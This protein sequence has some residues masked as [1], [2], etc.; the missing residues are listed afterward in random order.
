M[1][2]CYIFLCNFNENAYLC[3]KKCDMEQFNI[4]KFARKVGGGQRARNYLTDSMALILDSDQMGREMFLNPEPIRVEEGRIVRVVSGRGNC[5]FNLED[6]TLVPHD[7]IIIPPGFII[8]MLAHSADFALEAIVVKDMPGIRQEEYANLKPTE[9]LYL[10]LEA[11][12]WQRLTAYI[13]LLASLLDRDPPSMLAVHHLIFSC[14]SDL[15][16]LASA[17]TNPRQTVRNASRGEEKFHEFLRLA[18]EHGYQ[19]RNISFYAE[20]LLTTPNHLSA[21]V[22]QQ[23]GQTVIQ[24][25]TQRTLIE[26]R[27]LLRHSDLMMYEIA[28][29]LCFPEATAFGR[30]FKKHTGMTPLE[31]KNQK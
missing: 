6:Y 20:R 29:R 19:E 18:N 16:Q 8:E 22:R 21:I 24:W 10:H 15:R 2:K 9:M 11:T 3:R 31:Y 28:Q 7:V 4:D 1:N 25:L 26:A 30:Y 13:K 17:A 5:R 27:I 12:D 14:V 23:S